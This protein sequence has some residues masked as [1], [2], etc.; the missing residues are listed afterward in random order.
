MHRRSLLVGLAASIITA[1]SIVRAASLMPVKATPLLGSLPSGIT[2][3]VYYVK[4]VCDANTFI[5]TYIEGPGVGCITSVNHGINVGDR[6]VL[7][8]RRLS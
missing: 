8:G 6:I 4:S 7:E 1:P 3:A 5:V 2:S